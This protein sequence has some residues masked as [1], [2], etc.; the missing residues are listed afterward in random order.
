MGSLYYLRGRES[1][2]AMS[3]MGSSKRAEIIRSQLD[4]ANEREKHEFPAACR[5]VR[6]L[7][8]K[9]VPAQASDRDRAEWTSVVEAV[10][11]VAL[12]CRSLEE[13]EAR[14]AEQSA[15][16]RAAPANAVVLSTIHSAK[17]LEWDAVFMVGMEDGVLPARQQ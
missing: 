14:I 5:L 9:A 7:V 10:V 6:N 15:T 12:S 2:E 4:Q 3:R 13:L 17:G 1:L 11:S 8:A 16:L